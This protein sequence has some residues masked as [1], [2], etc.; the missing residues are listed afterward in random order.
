ML[1]GAWFG[2]ELV[3]MADGSACSVGNSLGCVAPVVTPVA[4]GVAE[5]DL[6]SRVAGAELA[7][8]PF[9]ASGIT[10]AAVVTPEPDKVGGTVLGGVV[11]VRGSLLVVD[12]LAG[13]PPLG[14]RRGN[15]LGCS[16][17][18]A[19]GNRFSKSV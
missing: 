10:A 1:E 11:D 15:G 18:V 17:S 14:L 4:A 3:D 13:F 5:R 9:W 2:A 16:L 8:I 6:G 19:V 12:E 7:V